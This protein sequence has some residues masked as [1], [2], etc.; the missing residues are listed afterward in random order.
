[1]RAGSKAIR[2]V[3]FDVGGT[4]LEPRGSVGEIYAAVAAEWGV[5]GLSPE[6]LTQRFRAAWQARRDFN[7]SR[8]EWAEVVDATFHGLTPVP[9]SR[10]FFGELYRRFATSAAWHVYPDVR[11]ALTALAAR[12][13]RLAVISNWDQRL[14]PLLRRLGLLPH[15]AAVVVSCEAG[16]AKPAPTIFELAARQLCLCP[17]EILHVGDEVACDLR[18][19]RAAGLRAVRIVRGARLRPSPGQITSLHALQ[20]L[21]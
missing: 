17:D 2:A 5:T 19:A 11:P 7:H 20:K 14:R 8:A 21:L 3:T 6:L 13:C 4:L 16:F 18:G 12:G 1:V 9:P 15:F 10:T